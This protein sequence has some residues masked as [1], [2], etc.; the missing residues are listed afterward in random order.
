VE[1]DV[2]D[3]FKTSYRLN[4]HFMEEAPDSAEVAMALKNPAL[5]NEFLSGAPLDLLL[6]SGFSPSGHGGANNNATPKH[7]S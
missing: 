2:N 3:W 7:L 5:R 6:R 1:K 4:K